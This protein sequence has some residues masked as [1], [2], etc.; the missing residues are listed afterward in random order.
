M[1][2]YYKYLV[3]LFTCSVSVV[4]VNSQVSNHIKDNTLR[5]SISIDDAKPSDTL[6]LNLYSYF[7]P[8]EDRIVCATLDENRLY[9]F[10]VP[11]NSTYGYWEIK[12]LVPIPAND[13]DHG[14]G[15]RFRGLSSTYYWEAGDDI[16]IVMNRKQ[17]SKD[18]WTEKEDYNFFV[19]GKGSLKYDLQK[20]IEP[21]LNGID[22][23]P[24]FNSKF[25]YH[26]IHSGSYA[27]ILAILD[28]NRAGLTVSGY[29]VLKANAAFWNNGQ[30]YAFDFFYNKQRK[31]PAKAKEFLNALKKQVNSILY[32]VRDIP[33]QY[34]C[35][36]WAACFYFTNAIGAVCNI[37]QNKIVLLGLAND[38]VYSVLKRRFKGKLRDQLI[39]F[40]LLISQRPAD[41][42]RI[43]GD[44]LRT[45]K[46][47]YCL[48]KL[49]SIA[50]TQSPGK[51]VFEFSLADSTGQLYSP[52]NFK[53]RVV[54]VDFWYTGCGACS[55]FYKTVISGIENKY[56]DNKNIVFVTVSIDVKDYLWKRSLRGGQYTGT[57]S[58]NLFTNGQGDMSPLI[59]YY[60]IK[61][62]PMAML[63]DKE[64][65]IFRF[66]TADLYEQT[67]LDNAINHLL[68]N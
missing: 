6:F 12:K 1:L 18:A 62:Y 22:K 59:E 30:F 13:T 11:V 45:V 57:E 48:Q 54:F 47:D 17:E 56:K 44:A 4:A 43:I 36:S 40:Y 46:T 28:S 15:N 49:K 21:L 24:M 3:I 66:N 35:R 33:G 7:Y 61:G 51:K 16:K 65:R 55:Q 23:D 50:D 41:T 32:P 25:E 29:N 37:E 2:K 64:G 42:D 68:N 34:I 8:L 9:K 52:G 63:L 53:S 26:N 39:T 5:V 67:S 38:S 58:I 27:R 10:N 14:M 31:Y 20:R 19:S 60:N